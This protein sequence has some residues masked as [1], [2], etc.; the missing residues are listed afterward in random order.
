MKLLLKRI[1]RGDTY[2]I[3]HL[4][5][6]GQYFCDTIEDR[7]RIVNDDCS[8]K[9]YGETAIPEG[10]YEFKMIFWTKH[11]N[12][13]P[14]ILDVPCFTGIF[15]HS[16]ATEKDSE[17]CILV[18]QNKTKGCLVNGLATMESL[19][20]ILLANKDTDNQIEII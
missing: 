13:Y 19:R 20:K 6:D 5:I 1:Y 16:G 18:G 2:T 9:I 8:L 4:Y 15:I 7:C 11:N 12:Y 17:G 14:N 10:Q 3:G